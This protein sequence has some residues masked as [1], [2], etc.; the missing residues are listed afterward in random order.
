M[1]S[2]DFHPRSGPSGLNRFLQASHAASDIVLGNG[3]SLDPELISD[4][5]IRS[6][7]ERYGSSEALVQYVGV[8]DQ[9]ADLLAH[10]ADYM[11]AREAQEASE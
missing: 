10:L 5:L 4:E 1:I 7:Q 9:A 6:V 3:K 11:A 8:L 2:G